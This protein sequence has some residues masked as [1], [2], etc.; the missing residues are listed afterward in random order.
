MKNKEENNEQEQMMESFYRYVG[1][2]HIENVAKE[3]DEI[4]EFA[5]DIEYPKELDNGVCQISC[6]I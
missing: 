2:Q 3:F 6:R 1:Y 5:K 4:S